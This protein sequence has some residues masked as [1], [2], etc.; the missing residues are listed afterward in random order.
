[1]AVGGLAAETTKG[2][3]MNWQLIISA[4]TAFIIGMAGTLT[5]AIVEAKGNMPS[6]PTWIVC[7]F[8]ALAVSAK[9]TRSFMKLPPVTNDQ[10]KE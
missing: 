10:T 5:A 2:K 4:V 8:A 6:T 7:V 9:D 1:M 3:T